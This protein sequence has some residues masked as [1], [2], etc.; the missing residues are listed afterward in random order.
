[1]TRKSDHIVLCEKNRL[2]SKVLSHYFGKSYGNE[3][4]IIYK[5]NAVH[6]FVG[7]F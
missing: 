1:M 2:Q 6:L 3:Q 7:D 4:Q 5:D